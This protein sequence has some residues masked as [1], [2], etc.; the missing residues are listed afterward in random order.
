MECV[1]LEKPKKDYMTPVE[2]K[3]AISEGRAY[4]RVPCVPFMGE[5]KCYL[6]GIRIWDFWHVPE[7]IAEAEIRAFNRYGYDRI[8]IGPNTRGIVE[9][10]G[11]KVIYP[12]KRLPYTDRP[13]L[14]DYKMLNKM[15]PIDADTSER[16]QTFARAADLICTQAQEIVPVEASIGG[17]FTIASQL[18]G[19]EFLLRD[20]RKSPEEVHRLMRVVTDS[21]KSCID[22][23]SRFGMGIA[24]ADPVANPELLGPKMY[25]EFVFPY[26]KELTDH[27]LKR[28]GR[29]VSLHMCGRTNSIWSYF[30]SYEL[31]EI[32]LDNIID[33]NQAAEE[34]GSRIPIAGNVDPVDVILNGTKEEIGNAVRD[35]ID[36]GRKAHK[37]F[38]L[39]TGCDIP[40]T[41]LPEKIDV[42][43]EAARN[44]YR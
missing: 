23:A 22:M 33:L 38:V 18:R 44:Y 16:I 6:S 27:A 26:T 20:C 4:D 24:M 5:F 17:P 14:T 29:K 32:S 11:G 31:N 42:F 28:C 3:K 35:C 12:E 9:A 30:C 19:V 21:Q 1:R 41:T 39:A 37:G 13:M 8:V 2:R 40:E 10:M 7:K 43:M 36:A 34:L 25:G 15:E